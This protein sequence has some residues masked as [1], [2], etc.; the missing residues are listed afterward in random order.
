MAKKKTT[1]AARS[2][3]EA[4]ET[5]AIQRGGEEVVLTKSKDVIAVK[6]TQ[7]HGTGPL[8]A[9]AKSPD[10]FAS[11]RLDQERSPR[12]L[13]L[14]RVDPA[15]CNGAMEEL[16]KNSPDVAW[17][18]HVYHSPGDLYGMMIPTDGIYVE[19]DPG[20]DDET[21][22][23][24]LD[25]HGLELIPDAAGEPNAFVMRLTSQST[26]NPLK[27]ANALR[28]SSAVALAEPDLAVLGRLT[29]YRPTDDLFPDQWHLENLGGFGLTAGADVSAPQ[30]WD[31][32]RGD[33]D[34]T[35]AVIDDGFDIGHPDFAS[36]GKIRSQRDFG[37]GDV[38][39]SP[40]TARDN[41][42]TACAGVAVAD[43]NGSGVVGIAPEC[44]LMPI[45][46]SGTVS[47]DDIRE[48]FDHARV[49]G[50][51]VISCSWGVN[52]GL[53]TLST[54]MK[55]SIN[56]AATQGRDGK[57]CVIVFAAGNDSHDI[58]D[59]PRTRAGFAIH[60]DV[61]AVAAS[62]SRDRQS[63]Y[64][65]FGDQIWVCAPSSGA[66]GLGIVTTDRRGSSGYQSGD[67]TTVRRFGGTSSATP[68][69]AGI[70]ALMLSVNPDLT[71]EEV[72]E[73]LKDTAEKIDPQHGNYDQNGHS[74]IFGF[75]RVNAHRAVEEVVRRRRGP[76]VERVVRFE[77][78]P[79]LPIPDNQPVGVTDAI[80]V[81]HASSVESV[82]VDIDI[83]H[84]FRGD[85]S[86]MLVGP[87]GTSVRLFGRTA[88]VFD[89]A[90][91]LVGRFTTDNVPALEQFRGKI[92]SGNWTLQVVDL[93]AADFGKLNSW[94]L[95][96]GLA[97]QQTEWHAAPGLHIPDNN[98][99]GIA[100]DISVD[101]RGVLRNIAVTVDIT[102]TYRGDLSVSVE[103]PE[104][105]VASLRAVNV[106][107]GQDDLRQT[108]T[109]AD[110]PSL[111]QLVD[112]GTNIY[113]VWRLHVS[114]NLSSDVGKLNAWSL[115]CM[116]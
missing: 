54:S 49:N 8:L 67:Y 59:P 79:S 82:Q 31:I 74:R 64:S 80:H 11:L 111:Q 109:A 102:H 84:T 88:P 4:H 76:L 40:V 5:I 52:T 69:V 61:I 100:S 33:P 28:E 43:D 21:I 10:R 19:L 114:D 99:T 47:D 25:L 81:D 32:S 48:Q 23:A 77:R 46:W 103:S 95:T 38:D 96:L 55:R 53:Y 101:A 44:G 113:G 98:A 36:P 6:R 87:D 68:L 108:Y 62:N 35:V 30:A 116:A 97:A 112:L 70:C 9:V 2:S 66:G 110:T 14:F 57:G 115:Q 65:N 39:P 24:L 37:Q 16:R 73:I 15:A 75:G 92:A 45:R 104:G 41:H 94:S 93:A 3:R 50:A 106:S 63:D 18:S 26:E 78:Q 58:D 12:G 105:S 71:A 34:I 22:N 90:D 7:V 13:E 29:I 42:G 51:D 107:E 56:R 72:K 27:I 17:C 20:A 83:T 1:T 91:N 89:A 60:P 85:L 86:V